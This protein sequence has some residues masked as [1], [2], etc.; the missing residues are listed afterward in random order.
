M[1]ARPRD[2]PV[3]QNDDPIRVPDGSDALR[4]DNAGDVFAFPIQGFP[5]DAVRL[6]IK[7]RE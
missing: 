2:L 3:L 1:T 7:G 4:Y 6:I 5:Q